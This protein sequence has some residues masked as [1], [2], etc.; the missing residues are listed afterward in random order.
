MWPCSSEIFMLKI[1]SYLCK[2]EPLLADHLISKY[3]II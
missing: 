2:V 1:P 3:L